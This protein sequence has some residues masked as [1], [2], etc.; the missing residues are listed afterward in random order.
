M[1]GKVHKAIGKFRFT[2]F[3]LVLLSG[4]V[5]PPPPQQYMLDALSRQNPDMTL[6][7]QA[8]GPLVKADA[9]PV[10]HTPAGGYTDFPEL[11]LKECNEPPAPE[12]P[13]ISGLWVSYTGGNSV[14]H[15]ERIEQAGYRIVITSTG[16]I[17]DMVADGTLEHGV[18]D[19]TEVDHKTPIRVAAKFEKEGLN[20]YP[21]GAFAYATRR[22]EGDE[23]VL[24]W[25]SK[26][27]RMK[28]VPY[29]LLPWLIAHGAK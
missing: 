16:V 13:D 26:I 9:I 2:A 20:L 19:V 17:H 3:L 8:T 29:S 21:Y 18:N 25:G 5:S 6:H 7:G 14:D 10:A 4:C 12:I 27:V 15:M 24:H 11:V 22:L 28:R 1:A 23:L